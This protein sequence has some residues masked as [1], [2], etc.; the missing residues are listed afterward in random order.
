M[1]NGIKLRRFWMVFFFSGGG[2]E[3]GR[4]TIKTLEKTYTHRTENKYTTGCL[5]N[6]DFSTQRWFD[7]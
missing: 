3:G 5:E 2:R 1:K 6:V 7:H 4:A